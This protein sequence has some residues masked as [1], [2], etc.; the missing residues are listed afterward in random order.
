MAEDFHRKA[1]G[2]APTVTLGRLKNNTTIAAF[3]NEE[4]KSGRGLERVFGRLLNI[5]AVMN[6]ECMLLNLTN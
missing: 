5:F 3:T 1:D 2:L 4:W 6:S